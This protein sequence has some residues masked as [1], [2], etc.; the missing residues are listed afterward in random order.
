MTQ[1]SKERT[2]VT[3]TSKVQKTCEKTVIER[4]HKVTILFTFTL[5]F[6]S[7][8]LIVRHF[9]RTLYSFINGG[10]ILKLLLRCFL[11]LF[12]FFHFFIFFLSCSCSYVFSLPA[13]IKRIQ[14]NL[15]HL[16]ILALYGKTH[17]NSSPPSH[18]LVCSGDRPRAKWAWLIISYTEYFLP[19]FL[20]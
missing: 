10:G 13:L 4:N 5:S 18:S 8:A 3:R 20:R 11:S 16:D 19:H 2:L 12:S 1:H 15:S 6:Q 17:T 7:E 9:Y 14:V